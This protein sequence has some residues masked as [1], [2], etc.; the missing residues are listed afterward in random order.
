M[1]TASSLRLSRRATWDTGTYCS[2]GAGLVSTLTFH[3]E[4]LESLAPRGFSLATDVADWLVRQRV[5]F[6]EAHH[7]AGATVRYCEERSL[8]LGDL[9]AEQLVEISPSL[10][11]GVLA[12]LTVHGSIDSRSGR[13][14]TARSSVMRQCNDVLDEIDVIDAWLAPGDFLHS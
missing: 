5:P 9:T 8:E 1:S 14:G 4:R 6:A 3:P 13:G 7:I 10:T 12:V 2:G 11:P